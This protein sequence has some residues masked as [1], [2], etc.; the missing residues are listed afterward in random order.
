MSGNN[1]KV[2]ADVTIDPPIGAH[3]VVLK[4]GT[5]RY[6]RLGLREAAFLEQLDGARTLQEI[7]AHDESG[8]S[9][10]Q[11]E[12]MIRWFGEN[13]LLE[14]MVSQPSA[15]SPWYRRAIALVVNTDGEGITLFNPDPFLNRHRAYVDALFSRPA[16]GLYL[17]ILM[18][19]VFLFLF[20][21]AALSG[22]ANPSLPRDTGTW[23]LLYLLML[24]TGFAHELAH[25]LT[26]K[27]FNG[28]VPRI[29]A[30]LMYLHPVLYCDVS[31]SWRF[32]HANQKVTVSFA[33]IFLQLLL[34]SLAFSAWLLTGWPLLMLYAVANLTVVLFNLFPFVKLDGYWMTVHYLGDPNLRLKSLAFLDN[35]VRRLVGRPLRQVGEHSTLYVTYGIGHAIAVPLFWATGFAG[36]LRLSRW[37][38][39]PYGLVLV[40]TVSLIL[41]TRLIRA[42]ITYVRSLRT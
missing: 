9:A 7:C 21:P 27:H 4:A 40:V 38:P 6:F 2:A 22:A 42:S 15:S 24:L 25:A 36:L 31:D 26:C 17:L 34:A 16:L 12:T 29:G 19:P 8:F 28:S 3:R 33:G 35:L 32:P 41:S 30:K 39:H 18:L 14:G 20:S 10:E 1:P 5:R 23:V 13:Q 11:V 37:M